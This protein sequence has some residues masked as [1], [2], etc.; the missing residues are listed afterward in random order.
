MTYFKDDK[1]EVLLHILFS[2]DINFIM[3]FTANKV[4]N[5]LLGM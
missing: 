3:G 1:H 2:A 4:F 5:S